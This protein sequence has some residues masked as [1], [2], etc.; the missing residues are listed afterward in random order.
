MSRTTNS[1][2]GSMARTIFGLGLLLS[3]GS[4][5]F[6]QNSGGQTAAVTAASP[7][8]D[9]HTSTNLSMP[10]IQGGVVR[11]GRYELRQ[12]TMLD[13]IAAAYGVDP[14]TVFG[15]P[16]WLELDRFDVIA[17]AP[18]DSSPDAAKAML[19]KLLEERFGLAVHRDTK[20]IQGLALTSEKGKPKLKA[21][22][23]SSEPGCELSKERSQPG[24]APYSVATCRN[25]TMQRFVAALREFASSDISV[26]IADLTGLSGNW[27]FDLKWTDR[28]LLTSASSDI[29]LYNAI[30]KQLG[31]LLERK[32]VRMSVL[33]VD[34][35]NE[36]PAP[37]PPDTPM[38]L[39]P[40]PEFEAGSIK[41]SPP[42]RP[43]GGGGFLPGGR[44]E[45]R[46][47]PL[48]LL[49]LTAWDLNYEPDEI[50]GAPKW[51][52][53][54]EPS[55]DVVAKAP[56]D[57]IAKGAQLYQ[58]DYQTM[59][60]ALLVERFKIVSHYEERPMNTYVLLSEKP[61]LRKADP[62]N[63]PGCRTVRSSGPRPSE[64][65]PLPMETTCKNVTLTQFAQQLQRIAPVYF[66]YPVLDATR[67]E[68][69]WDF[70][71]TFSPIPPNLIAGT[72]GVLRSSGPAPVMPTV[73]GAS[74]PV[75]G[76]SLLDAI[77]KQ[78]GL[79]FAVEKRPQP[80]FVIDHIEQK[81]TD[82]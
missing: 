81:P 10:R 9:I 31:L 43:P 36:K 2:P 71:F 63:R 41:P 52:T 38:L 3:L 15:G 56:A 44:V 77:K 28:R 7:I 67:I 20:V 33:V 82:N 69:A 19:Q 22:G 74:D 16:A 78:L 5:A 26:P 11:S 72:G 79:K 23:G 47:M 21:A 59:L 68:G 60:Q 14:D 61:N 13:L 42:G 1:Y 12:A 40:P 37:N 54:F 76:I 32:A 73:E 30:A 25:V 53:P 18:P 29:T 51:L 46:A 17:K 35:V 70:T 24:V 65:A 57:A 8:A 49:I 27:D 55:F 6:S 39:P 62:S 58:S 45:M 66:R 4:G 64:L 50:P 75:G 80:V 48:A 34:H